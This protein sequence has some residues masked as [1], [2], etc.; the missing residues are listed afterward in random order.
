MLVERAYV[1]CVMAICRPWLW[2]G[3]RRVREQ[4]VETWSTACAED[5][6]IWQGAAGETT[7]SGG[8]KIGSHRK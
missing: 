1:L 5:V 6:E 2:Q 7:G 3:S 8:A 4:G